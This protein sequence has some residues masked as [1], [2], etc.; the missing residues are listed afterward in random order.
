M[1][2]CRRPRRSTSAAATSSR[3]PGVP[4][5]SWPGSS[6]L[7]GGIV[8]VVVVVAGA[9]I[10]G[11]SWTCVPRVG[12]TVLAHAAAGPG[13]AGR[14]RRR[15]WSSWWSS[16]SDGS[17]PPWATDPDRRTTATIDSAT[18][19]P[20]LVCIRRRRY[21]VDVDRRRRRGRQDD[22][23]AELLAFVH[24]DLEDRAGV[25]E[26][27]SPGV[28]RGVHVGRAPTRAAR[29][30]RPAGSAWPRSSPGAPHS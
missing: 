11:V 30:P 23:A 8:V 13:I 9:G 20:N 17:V 29:R 6:S 2:P 27:G 10:V 4:H 1:T 22:L 3:R 16:S 7:G 28:D 19:Q 5:R 12:R 14:G 15:S 21:P 26:I 25:G 24:R 18:P